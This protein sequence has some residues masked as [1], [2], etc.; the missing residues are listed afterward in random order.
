MGR[1]TEIEK[2]FHRIWLGGPIPD[3]AQQYW[4]ALKSL[5]PSW[6][7]RTW[8]AANL[9][10]LQNQKLFDNASSLTVGNPYQLQSDIARYEILYK[11]SGVYVDCDIEPLQPFDTL[12]THS[13]FAGWEAQDRWVNNAVLAAS[14]HHPF[15][16]LLIDNLPDSV[17]ANRKRRPNHASGPRYITRLHNENPGHLHVFPESYFYPYSWAELGRENEEF[18]DSYAVHHWD[19]ARRMKQGIHR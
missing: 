2:C 13:C 15:L 8:T 19:N 4:S 1:T 11:Y 6:T 3:S 18:P 7:F 10:L 17:A 9:T 12:L 5:H 16:R 14:H